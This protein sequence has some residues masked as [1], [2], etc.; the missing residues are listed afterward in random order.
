[1]STIQIIYLVLG[2]LGAIF[3]TLSIIGMDG[4]VEVD[5]GDADVELS[6]AGVGVDS[7]SLISMRTIATFLLL[8]G[9]IGYLCDYMG[10]GTFIQL[11]ISTGAGFGTA[12]LYGLV[13]KG[14]YAMQGDSS[15]SSTTLIGK[16]VIVTTPTVSSGICQVKFMEVGVNDEY[17]AREID[18][19]KLKQHDTAIVKF[20]NGGILTIK[21]Q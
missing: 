11:L 3:L 4:D 19:I 12:L 20:S 6:D 16:T 7:P 9:I 8:F 15:V 2:A 14:M 10:Y 18:N 13:M 17:T 1:M 5:I 21:K